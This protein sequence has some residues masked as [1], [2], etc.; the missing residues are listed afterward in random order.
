MLKNVYNYYVQRELLNSDEF[1]KKYRKNKG[2]ISFIDERK[3]LIDTIHKHDSFYED[4][5][6][7][8]LDRKDGIIYCTYYIWHNLVYFVD[9][10]FKNE[11]I[12][13][14]KT[15]LNTSFFYFILS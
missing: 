12:N 1:F 10:S 8:G 6:L 14:K 7:R 13:C 5:K 4:I 15:G 9:Y 2:I 11:Y 3:F